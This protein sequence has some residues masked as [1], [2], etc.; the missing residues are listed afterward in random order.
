MNRT[1]P[2]GPTAA[3]IT[4]SY[5]EEHPSIREALSADLLNYT[6]L[7]RKIQAERSV[8]NE[9]AVTI[10]CRR[11]ERG[12]RVETPE[13]KAVRSILQRSRLQVHSRVAI[14]RFQ[15]DWEVL[16]RLLA[17]GRATLPDL[18]QR[19][20]FQLFQGTV[21]LT[22]LCEEDYLGTLL[23]EIPARLR[24]TVERGLATLAFR[25]HPEVGDT[26]GVLAYMADALFRRGINCLETVSVHTDSIFVF[27]DA[28]VI[29]AYQ[30]LSDLFPSG[31]PTP[32]KSRGQQTGV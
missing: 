19:R 9:E 15:D 31:P 5:I 10:A 26:P 2:S 13:L 23:P 32:A 27:R 11:Y 7:A 25:S 29:P 30:V 21:A 18:S 6:A 16:D 12:M 20:V 28:D 24:L 22:L 17:L 8:A 4:R 14:V 1:K 3:D